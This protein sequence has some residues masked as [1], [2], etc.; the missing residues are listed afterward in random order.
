M[1]KLLILLVLVCTGSVAFAQGCAT[2]TKTAAGL[3]E[4]GA[5]GLNSGII[6]LASLPLLIMGTVG[7]MWWRSNKSVQ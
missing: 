2:C 7:F 3:G 6:Y 1:K 5:Q 4:A